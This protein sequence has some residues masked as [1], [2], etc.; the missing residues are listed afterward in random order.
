MPHS[1]HDL[2]DKLFAQRFVPAWKLHQDEHSEV[3]EEV[4]QC[5]LVHLLSHSC[6]P[7]LHDGT[8]ISLFSLFLILAVI[9]RILS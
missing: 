5:Q 3:D 6:F 8:N 7:A 2:T 9:C 4:K 1:Q